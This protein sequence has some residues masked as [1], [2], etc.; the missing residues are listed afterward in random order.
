MRTAR[1]AP[2][3]D[4]CVQC[5]EDSCGGCDVLL[6]PVGTCPVCG[7]DVRRSEAHEMRDGAPVHWECLDDYETETETEEES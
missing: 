4:L 3:N 6:P 7:R 1:G 5:F 2:G